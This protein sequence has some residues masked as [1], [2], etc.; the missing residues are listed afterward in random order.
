MRTEGC[1]SHM[2][3]SV[4]AEVPGVSVALMSAAGKQQKLHD[5]DKRRAGLRCSHGLS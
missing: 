3:V 2:G 1:Q 4:E 5:V